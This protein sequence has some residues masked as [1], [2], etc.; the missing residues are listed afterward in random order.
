MG[1]GQLPNK[2]CSL[3]RMGLGKGVCRATRATLGIYTEVRAQYT[4][5]MLHAFNA[6]SALSQAVS[7]LSNAV[8]VLSTADSVLFRYCCQ[9]FRWFRQL[10]SVVSTVVSVLLTVV[11]V[12][13]TTAFSG[14]DGCFGVIRSSRRCKCVQWHL[15]QVSV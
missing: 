15:F 5:I 3:G 1:Q 14:I 7:V 2:C 13:S 9:L 11:S 10:L 4:I 12:V 8:S 6:I